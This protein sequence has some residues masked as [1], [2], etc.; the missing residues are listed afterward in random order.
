MNTQITVGSIA[1]LATQG[2]M[3][4]AES[5][6]S[7]DTIIVID[8]SGS[9]GAHDDGGPQSRYQVALGELARLQKQ[10]PGKVAVVNFSS[11]VEFV[12][13][14]MPQFLS[15]GTNLTKALEFVKVA[16]GLVRFIV[17]SDGQP[18]D[19]RSALAVA[20]T[21]KSKIDVVY[22]GPEDDYLGGRG[23]LERLARASGGKFVTADRARELASTVETLLLSA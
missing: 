6:L 8:T 1:D 22:I 15:G 18:D 5:F 7:A 11:T 20:S 2:K 4:I 3:S 13:G 17:I 10:L 23:F 19:E 14:G 21:F 16:D 12:P 9:M